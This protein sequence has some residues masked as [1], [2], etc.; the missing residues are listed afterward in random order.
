MFLT[1]LSKKVYN[2]EYEDPIAEIYT[3]N[4][5]IVNFMHQICVKEVKGIGKDY[6]NI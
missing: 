2:K 4:E 3:Y 6:K 1:E 5:S